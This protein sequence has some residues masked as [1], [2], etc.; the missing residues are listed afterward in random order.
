MPHG[1]PVE[2]HHTLGIE[3]HGSILDA[4]VF[5]GKELQVGIM[6]SNNPHGMT[7]IQLFDD[8]LGNGAARARLGAA[9]QLVDEEKRTVVGIGQQ[10][11]HI[12]EVRRVGA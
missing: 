12:L 5:V 8:G 11:L 3:K 4:I 7:L 9:T 2:W 6:G 10:L 1:E